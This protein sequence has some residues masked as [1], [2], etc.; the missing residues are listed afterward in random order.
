MRTHAVSHISIEITNT[1]NRRWQLTLS[2]KCTLVYVSC[3]LFTDLKKKTVLQVSSGEATQFQSACLS[4]GYNDDPSTICGNIQ[5]F[6]DHCNRQ[7][8]SISNWRT[9][10]NCRKCCFECVRF[11]G[12]FTIALS[13]CTECSVSVEPVYESADWL[14]RL[15]TSILL[16]FELNKS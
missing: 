2:Y 13:K 7:G 11:I 6:A 5:A 10:T 1:E 4:D 8:L 16:R 12:W 9:S 3:L 15:L 14:N